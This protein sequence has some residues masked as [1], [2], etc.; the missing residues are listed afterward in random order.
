MPR[1]TDRFNP[2]GKVQRAVADR[3]DPVKRG[4]CRDSGEVAR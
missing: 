1:K 2:S 3:I 4:A